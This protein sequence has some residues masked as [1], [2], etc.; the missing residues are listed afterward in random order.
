MTR[1]ASDKQGGQDGGGSIDVSKLLYSLTN[2]KFLS[3]HA[4][5]LGPISETQFLPFLFFVPM[6]LTLH[7][8]TQ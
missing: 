1:H 3:P 7:V 6:C 4:W 5:Q 2:P 8:T